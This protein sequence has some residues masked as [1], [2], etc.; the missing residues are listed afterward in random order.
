MDNCIIRV[1]CPSLDLSK[2]ARIEEIYNN[3]WEWVN[4]DALNNLLSLFDLKISPSNNFKKYIGSLQEGVSKVWDYRKTKESWHIRDEKFVMENKYAIMECARQLGFTDITQ[5]LEE[6]DY[7][8]P[9]GGARMANLNRCLTAKQIIDYNGWKNKKVVALSGMRPIDK[10]ELPY[11]E[12]Y[13]SE[14]KIS[15]NITTEYDVMCYSIEK[16]FG[17]KSSFDENKVVVKNINECSAVRRYTSSANGIDVYSVA[18]PSSKTDKRANS[19][20]TFNYFLKLFNVK[21]NEKILL[22][23]NC[24]YQP[25]Q[26]LSFIMLSLDY[27]VWVDCVGVSKNIETGGHSVTSNYLQEIKAMIDTIKLFCDKY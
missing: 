24:I 27:D 22:T 8:C 26:L 14:D 5:P 23:T 19:I 17:L 13:I 18:A 15:E 21:K 2:E 11:L 1:K 10:I 25:R 16:A 7:I 3:L 6:V 9:L 12:E 4:S 20:D